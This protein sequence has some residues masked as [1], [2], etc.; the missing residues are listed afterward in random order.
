MEI[1]AKNTTIDLFSPIKTIKDSISFFSDNIDFIHLDFSPSFPLSDKIMNISASDNYIFITEFTSVYQFDKSGRFIR[2]VGHNGRGPGEYI[3]IKNVQIDCKT[4]TINIFPGKTGSKII[5][6]D[7]NGTFLKEIKFDKKQLSS[8]GFDFY[9]N[10]YYFHPACFGRFEQDYQ[11]IFVTDSL[12][13]NIHHFQSYI[14]P[15]IAKDKKKVIC[16]GSPRNWS[17]RHQN[18]LYFLEENNDTIFSMAKDSLYF[19]WK[20]SGNKK[21]SP[22]KFHFSWPEDRGSDIIELV[23]KDIIVDNSCIYETDRYLLFRCLHNNERYFSVYDKE[24]GIL[25]RT[26]RRYFDG[27][28]YQSDCFYDDILTGLN[29]GLDFQCSDNQLFAV[30]YPCDIMNSKNDILKFSGKNKMKTEQFQQMCCNLTENDNPV[31]L[32]IEM[33]KPLKKD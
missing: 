3:Q 2:K 26:N 7:F 16:Y 15:N 19:R 20:L 30:L 17:W 27:E 28:N 29:V 22:E 1:E 33:K 23:N 6:Y 10:C 11:M 9:D 4:N 12:G 18:N 31:L 21:S 5:Q 25:Y 24:D 8:A 14:Y 13:R 32:I